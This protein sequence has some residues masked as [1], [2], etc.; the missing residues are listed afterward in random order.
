MMDAKLVIVEGP[1][2]GGKSTLCK[3]LEKQLSGVMI[4]NNEYRDADS[5]TL[6]KIFSSQFEY[7]STMV[8]V[9][10]PVILDRSYF[11]ELIY[12][13]VFRG[14]SRI[15]GLQAITLGKYL[16]LLQPMVVVCRPPWE[17][18][19]RTFMNRPDE[20]MLDSIDQLS[21]VYKGYDLREMKIPFDVPVTHYDYTRDS[22]VRLVQD[23]KSYFERNSQ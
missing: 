3:T 23:V 16:S 6:A 13:P 10:V 12:G 19:R 17:A 5:D 18:V 14:E 15:T 4:H 8:P 2:A 22:A 7:A 9:G 1:D 20:E 11:S 21:K